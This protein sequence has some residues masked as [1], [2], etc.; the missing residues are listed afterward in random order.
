MTKL[1]WIYWSNP[2]QLV[3]LSTIFKKP[4]DRRSIRISNSLNYYE[5]TAGGVFTAVLESDCRACRTIVKN[6]RVSARIYYFI[7]NEFY[8][9]GLSLF[10][11]KS[12][13]Y[14]V[15]SRSPVRL[16]LVQFE[17]CRFIE[18]KNSLNMDF[19]PFTE[20]HLDSRHLLKKIKCRNTW[21]NPCR[22][23]TRFTEDQ[24]NSK[25]WLI[26][27]DHCRVHLILIGRPLHMGRG[28]TLRR[29]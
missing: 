14:H 6:Y 4:M 21:T 27:I 10:S 29:N 28:T 13:D 26:W 1:D 5:R 23:Y 15:V 22:S 9:N 19:S 25:K 24:L 2:V 20:T 12:S 3:S 8:K 17:Q 18:G 11:L 16:W 7:I